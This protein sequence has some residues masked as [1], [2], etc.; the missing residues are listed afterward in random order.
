MMTLKGLEERVSKR[1]RTIHGDT[2][3][4]NWET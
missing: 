3:R 4:K 2:E 1:E